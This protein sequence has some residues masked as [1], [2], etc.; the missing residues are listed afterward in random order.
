MVVLSFL[1]GGEVVCI[2]L[3]ITICSYN[4][5]RIRLFSAG[6]GSIGGGLEVAAL[7]H[8]YEQ[9]WT[10]ISGLAAA[11]RNTFSV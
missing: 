4:V 3:N 7:L 8:Y 10:L 6:S 2:S 1:N 9:I 11:F 5:A